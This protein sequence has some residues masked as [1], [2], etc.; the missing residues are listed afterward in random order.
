MSSWIHI[1]SLMRVQFNSE[2][3]D[4]VVSKIEENITKI[5]FPNGSEGPMSCFVFNKKKKTKRN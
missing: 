3:F 5:G 4:D 1:N 2:Q